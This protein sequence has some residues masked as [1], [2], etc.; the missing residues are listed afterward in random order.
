LIWNYRPYQEYQPVDSGRD[1]DWQE[2]LA[3][4]KA[5]TMP[6]LIDKA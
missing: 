3:A 6:P 4:H 5:G 1:A 2:T